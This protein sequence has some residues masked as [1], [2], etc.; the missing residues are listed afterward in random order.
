MLKKVVPIM[1]AAI[2]LL[3]GCG[4]NPSPAPTESGSTNA[5][6][7]ETGNA[8]GQTIVIGVETDL[9]TLDPS[10]AY[11]VFGNMYFYA[12]YDNL[13]KLNGSS[14]TPEPCLA[15][16]YTYDEASMRYT[17]TL[18]EG[19]KFSSGNPITASDVVFSFNRAKNIKSNTSHHLEGVESVEAPDDKTVVVTLN[20]PDSSF[21]AKLCNNSMAVLDSKI[22][23][24]NGGTDGT[25]ASTADKAEE[26]LNTH[27]A[28]SGPYVLKSWTVKT[29]M[30]LEKN[31]NYWGEVANDVIIIKEIPDPNAQL[32]MLEKGEIDIAFGVGPDQLTTAQ[33]NPEIQ[34]VSSPT[35]TTSFLLM[36][37]DKAIGGPMA[38]PKVQEAVRLAIDYKGL[39]MLAGDGALNPL[40]FVPTGFS[41]GKQKPDNYQDIEKAKALLAEAGYAD[42]FETPLITPSF[43]VVG[44]PCTTIAQ[45]VAD[46]L[47]KIGITTKIETGEVNVI[48]EN[49]RNGQCPFLVIYWQPDYLDFANQLVFA[50]GDVVGLRANWKAEDNAEL[51]D[52]AQSALVEMNEN[53]RVKLS[54][55]MQDVMASNSPYVFLVQHPKMFAAAAKLEGI[56]FSNHYQ[57]QFNTLKLA[58]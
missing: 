58:E 3:S 9:K 34:I 23:I 47:S 32:Q 45:K 51:S 22:V 27:S 46:D 13:Y 56:H 35:V 53:E 38:D 8:A 41:G 42:G 1:V 39:G 10:K 50:P 28:G 49:Y 25:D 52:L 44:L 21:M 7:T 29:E 30:V 4:G 40:S 5:N 54:E 37:N 14:M 57:L 2:M 17:F 55:Q 11:E 18:Q 31:P 48:I 24:E 12:T 33:N 15:T 16:G 43:D 36:N 19:L 26:F 6:Q 20:A